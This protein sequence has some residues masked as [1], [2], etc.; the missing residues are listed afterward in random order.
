MNI[1]INRFRSCG[2]F[3]PLLDFDS[4]SIKIGKTVIW[5]LSLFNVTLQEWKDQRAAMGLDEDQYKYV[6]DQAG[7]DAVDTDEVKYLFGEYW[8]EVFYKDKHT[9]NLFFYRESFFSVSRM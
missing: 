6:V 3:P 1:E 8:K 2:F 7:F 5:F 9:N 4:T